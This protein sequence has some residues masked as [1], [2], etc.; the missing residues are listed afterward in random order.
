MGVWVCVSERRSWKLVYIYNEARYVK[1][2]RKKNL[3]LVGCRLG[4]VCFSSVS[5]QYNTTYNTSH[6]THILTRGANQKYYSART[7]RTVD[8]FRFDFDSIHTV[9]WLPMHYMLCVVLCCVILC[10]W[11]YGGYG[12]PRAWET[13]T[14]CCTLQR[15]ARY[16]VYGVCRLV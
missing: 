6:S 11:L 15:Y 1:N 14:C 8:D 4:L 13:S 16:A 12:R 7:D 5:L 9:C 2:E 10:F 3:Y